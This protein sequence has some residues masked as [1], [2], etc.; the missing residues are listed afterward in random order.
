MHPPRT[1][2]IT[3]ASDGIGAAAARRLHREGHRVV[4]VGRS[5]RKILA[6][7]EELGVDHQVTDFACLDDVRELANE[8]LTAYPDI[9]VLANN[10]GGVFGD[11]TKT[12]DGFERTFQ[13]NHLAP[14]L[15]TK[16]LM[17][18]LVA[19][20]ATVLQTVGLA[21]RISGRVEL[22]NLDYDRTFAS[23][24][25]YRTAKLESILF[26]GE[27]HRRYHSAGISTAA[28]HPG[29]LATSLET[30]S[31]DRLTRLTT[32]NKITRSLLATGEKGADQLVWLAK[33]R[34]GVDWHSGTYY[35]RCMPAKRVN[36]QTLDPALARRRWDRSE[37]LLAHTRRT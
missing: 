21:A 11:R 7:A 34:A 14:F 26:T 3:G 29:N 32:I 9:D 2:V 1:I 24:R 35:K 28:L 25:A 27:L 18:T 15:L 8:L 12:V 13:V 20:E 10:D 6:L 36:P 17:K 22:D 19:N 37:E 5:P 33:G 4:I 30:Q 31:G 16:L 23:F